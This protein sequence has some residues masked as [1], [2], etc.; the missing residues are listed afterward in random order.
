MIA[1]AEKEIE[2]QTIQER[3][4]KGETYINEEGD[5]VPLE[6]DQDESKKKTYMIKDSEG[7]M[8]VKNR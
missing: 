6:E 5:E 8:Q 3:L 1:E 2:E 4:A 7:H